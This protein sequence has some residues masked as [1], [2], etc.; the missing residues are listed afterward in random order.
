M[1]D[2]SLPSEWIDKLAHA[3][4]MEDKHALCRDIIDFMLSG[5]RSDL[6]P[7]AIEMWATRSKRFPSRTGKS[8]LLDY[9]IY[10]KTTKMEIIIDD[11]YIN[12]VMEICKNGDTALQFEEGWSGFLTFTNEVHKAT[13]GDHILAGRE[14]YYSGY[15]KMVRKAIGS[16]LFYEEVLKIGN[17]NEISE[18]LIEERRIVLSGVSVFADNIVTSFLFSAQDAPRLTFRIIEV[19]MPAGHRRDEI[20]MGIVLGVNGVTGRPIATP[21]ALFPITNDVALQ[22]LRDKGLSHPEIALE[23]VRDVRRGDEPYDRYQQLG[24]SEM[25]RTLDHEEILQ[26]WLSSREAGVPASA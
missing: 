23:F 20:F 14:K 17:R 24:L 8:L 18:N 21:I 16:N 12:H 22:G 9:I 10:V 3:L 25:V 11:D 2:R 5:R 7:R 19:L 6:T 15:Y 4:S 13:R 26:R 1:A